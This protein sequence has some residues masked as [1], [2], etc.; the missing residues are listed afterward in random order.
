MTPLRTHILLY[1]R[2][3]GY[4]CRLVLYTAGIMHLLILLVVSPSVSGTAD[5]AIAPLQHVLFSAPVMH[6]T[7]LV[8]LS[9]V[10]YT[11][12]FGVCTLPPPQKA[13][14]HAPQAQ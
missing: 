14:S 10:A 4:G 9:V 13:E 5:P 8:G 6:M 11:A 12:I 2:L 1:L 3:T 7:F